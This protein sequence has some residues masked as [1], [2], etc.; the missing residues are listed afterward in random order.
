MKATSHVKEGDEVNPMN[1]ELFKNANVNEV[2]AQETLT[3][4]TTVETMSAMARLVRAF[5][6]AQIQG[7]QVVNE[8]LRFYS[9]DE[10]I[11]GNSAYAL[12]GVG[13]DELYALAKASESE[14]GELLYDQTMLERL[15]PL[16]FTVELIDL[17]SEF[18][19]V[20]GLVNGY[21]WRL[22][23]EPIIEEY[24]DREG[25]I[26]F[27]YVEE[28]AGLLPYI[29][30]VLPQERLIFYTPS[31]S[32]FIVL[33]QLYP[34]ATITMEWPDDVIFD[35][36]VAATTGLF[37]APVT[38]MEELA[39]RV[40]NISEFGSAH[41]FIPL[42]AVQD[43]L[44]MNRMAIQFMLL[45]KRLHTI[46][47]WAPLSTYEFVY[48]EGDVKKVGLQIN[49]VVNERQ[50]RT[51]PFI[52]LP[53]EVLGS[54]ETFSMVAY[55][56]SLCGVEPALQAQLPTLGEDGYMKVDYKLPPYMQ[57]I[58]NAYEGLRLEVSRQGRDI[59]LAL[60]AHEGYPVGRALTEEA[61]MAIVTGEGQ[62]IAQGEERV[63][64]QREEHV[65]AQGADQITALGTNKG[66]NEA[67]HTDYWLFSDSRAAYIWYIFFT[68][69][70]GQLVLEKLGQMV[71]TTPAL[72]QL[73]SSVRRQILKDEQ[74]DKLATSFGQIKD[75]YEADLERLREKFEHDVDVLSSA[76]VPPE[77]EVIE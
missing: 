6:E 67:V 5:G 66:C 17:I 15:Y 57:K 9:I 3:S 42:G 63:T 55:A 8:M 30:K 53:H 36:V 37:R 27:A 71:T 10:Q 77:T 50:I 38:I 35:H 34:T 73:M 18:G 75:T 16:S 43:Q 22:P 32:A 25:I 20:D 2:Q 48:G 7:S 11:K 33:K 14:F 60:A 69:Q 47:E 44:G 62:A 58:T 1:N 12:R 76:V 56:L 52:K 46:R 65:T 51:T 68:S 41:Y 39:M 4:N 28:Y 64:G 24:A 74:L 21:Q 70:K 23:L 49:E 61:F 54:M 31:D 29:M 45:Q 19:L 40:G 59:A 26:L 72:L 13:G